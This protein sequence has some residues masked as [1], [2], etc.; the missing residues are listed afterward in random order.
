MER[1]KTYGDEK[2]KPLTI[3]QKNRTIRNIL[4]LI[5]HSSHILLLGHS[6]SDEDCVSSMLA[7]ALLL[8]KFDKCVTIYV[9]DHFPPSLS[10][11]KNICEYNEIEL[12]IKSTDDI[13]K[14]DAIF[15]LDT[16]KPDMLALDDKILD[17]F[18]QKSI[19]KVEIDHHF[20]KDARHTGD[21]PYRLTLHA[22]SS[23]E[24]IATIC[25]KLSKQKIVLEKNGIGELYSR[26]I[27]LTIL[28][29][30]I[31]DAKFGNYL[32][33]RRD[34]AFFKYFLNKLGSILRESHYI[35][36][37]N[38]SS[39]DEIL[40]LLEEVSEKEKLLYNLVSKKVKKQD[41]IGL[42]ILNEEDSLNL[43]KS[44]DDFQ[45]FI[46]I[47]RRITG[48]LSDSPNTASISCFYYPKSISNFVEFRVRA[49][50]I[51]KGIDFRQVIEDMKVPEGNGGGHPGAICFK[52][53]KRMIANINDYTK[54]LME[55]V[56][57][58]IKT[59]QNTILS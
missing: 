23:C 4:N 36:S 55:D 7:L 18:L 42:L 28:T 5:M 43:Q 22:S 45:D 41:S 1:L 11:F 8:R 21:A 20:S 50:E 38:I 15:I 49:G 35:N 48:E 56:L 44:A 12:A 52:V 3:S 27:V 53:E 14:P 2:L 32:S 29:G 40:H 17:F 37:G 16:P 58:I 13:I 57:K 24:I 59:K 31:G 9:K 46:A 33:S 47:V 34:R 30:M 25:Y 10:F 26:N 39:T 51:I 6:Y 19:P 54:K